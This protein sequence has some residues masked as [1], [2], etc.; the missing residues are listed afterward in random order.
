MPRGSFSI[1]RLTEYLDEARDHFGRASTNIVEDLINVPG[2]HDYTPERLR[3]YK[4][5][6]R[7]YLCYG[8][9]PTYAETS[10]GHLLQPVSDQTL[11]LTLAERTAYPVGYDLW[12]S[13]SYRVSQ[14]PQSGDVVGGGYGV[15]DLANFDPATI[16]YSGSDADGYFWYHTED[17]GLDEV[18]LALVASGEV[19]HSQRESLPKAASTMSILETRLNWYSVGPAT[20]QQSYTNIDDYPD[21]PQRNVDVGAVANDDGTASDLGSHRT[22]MSIHQ[23][24][25]NTGLELEAGSTAIKASGEPAYQFKT[26]G[27]SMDLTV[28]DDTAG[29]YEVCG[30]IRQQ[31]SR[32][33]VKLAMPD[34]N[35]IST[36]GASTTRTRVLLTAVGE[37]E[38][39]APSAF[40]STHLDAVPV[41]H[42]AANSVVEEVEDNTLVGPVEDDENTD[43][44]GPATANTMT[45]P[46]GYQIGRE[47]ITPEGTGTQTQLFQGDQIGRRKLYDTDVCLI[48][49]DA[50]T[51]GTCEI[52]VTTQQN[53]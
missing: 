43:A 49:V 53:S 15:I 45:N 30:A 21:E 20:T 50:T 1:R 24:S 28:T 8:D 12:P 7:A 19:L 25:G 5:G 42:N 2:E 41:E 27:H 14:M 13:M 44:S 9:D 48:L 16:S 17:T 46:G 38:T 11:T 22:V 34:V 29:V 35:I 40:P 10:Q 51:T 4:D 39:D 47:S 6:S 32:P 18:V 33:E 37:G 26:K 23:A 3:Y 52:D 36:P 31:P